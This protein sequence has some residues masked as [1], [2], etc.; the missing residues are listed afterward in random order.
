MSLFRWVLQRLEVFGEG[1]VRWWCLYLAH[2]RVGMASHEL[3]DLLARKVSSEGATAAED[4]KRTAL[5][6]ERGLRRYLQS[7]GAQLDFFHG[8]LRQAAFERYGPQVEAAGIHAD[9]ASYFRALA[10]PGRDQS[11]MGDSARGFLEVAFHLA[12]ASQLDALCQTLCDMRFVEARCRGGQV[13]E[14][15]ADYQLARETLPEAQADLQEKRDR[16]DRARRWAEETIAYARQWSERRD[17]AA[18]GEAVPQQEPPCPEPV[19][20]CE[21]WSEVAIRAERDRV[22]HSPTRRDSLDTFA[23]FSISQSYL[24]E[25]FGSRPGFVAQQAFNFAP[26]GPVH[27]AGRLCLSAERFPTVLRSRTADAP[28]VVRPACERTLAAHTDAVT[29]VDVSADGLRAISGSLDGTLR[30]WDL[31]SGACLRTLVACPPVAGFFDHG[32]VVCVSMTPDGR[33]AVSLGNDTVHVWDLETGAN[34]V[35]FVG[36]HLQ[37][38]STTPDGRM[39]ITG[40]YF[41]ALHVWDLESATCLRTLQQDTSDNYNLTHVAITP[42][43]RRTVSYQGCS[44]CASMDV[45]A[46]PAAAGPRHSLHPA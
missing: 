30:L 20:L 26:A 39:A 7:R 29:C 27:E 22:L 44:T 15:I 21:M 25:E 9:I 43:G 28:M 35:S 17:R 38:L 23:G 41:G 18:R 11:W 19:Q 33:R 36:S 42:D 4:A 45:M 13:F 31:E 3:A 8:Q 32:G 24:L 12:A 10:D 34:P 6:I 16:E 37:E 46:A 5:R 1:A 14:L 2:G 40:S